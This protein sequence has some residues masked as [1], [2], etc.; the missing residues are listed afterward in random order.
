MPP[1]SQLQE[2]GLYTQWCFFAL[3]ELEQT[4]VDHGQT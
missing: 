4:V 2:R 3:T 1:T